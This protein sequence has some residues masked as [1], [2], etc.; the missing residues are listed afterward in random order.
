MSVTPQIQPR[1]RL[2]ARVLGP[3][4]VVAA[5]TMISRMTYMRTTI[6]AF[7]ADAVWPWVT[8]AFV[9]PMGLVIIVLHPYWR[10][11]A[12][13]VVSLLGY[14][15]AF[16]G[17]ALMAFPQTYLPLGHTVINASPW[18]QVFSVIVAVIGLYLTYIGW[19]STRSHPGTHRAVDTAPELPRAA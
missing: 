9:L 6:D 5:L 19:I 2:F 11:P 1:T 17:I 8:G 12:A 13:T 3:Y 18:W 14:L 10:G 16:K 7:A 4:L 15:T